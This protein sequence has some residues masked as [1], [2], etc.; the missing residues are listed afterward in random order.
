MNARLRAISTLVFIL[1]PSPLLGE[2]RS[3]DGTGN[4][5][6]QPTQGAANTPFIRFNYTPQYA[7]FPGTMFIEPARPNARDVSNAIFAQSASRPSARNLSNYIWAWGQFLTHDTDLSTTSNG[8]VVNG[9][10]DCCP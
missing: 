9:A 1:L 6:A 8:P 7:A 5:I 2:N 3:I 10:A 4:N